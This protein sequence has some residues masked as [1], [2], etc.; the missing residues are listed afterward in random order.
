M[1]QTSAQWV[2][3]ARRDTPVEP[4]E[5]PWSRYLSLSQLD[6][7]IDLSIAPPAIVK[8]FK[9]FDRR[10]LYAYYHRHPYGDMYDR[11]DP[12]VW[13]SLRSQVDSDPRFTVIGPFWIN[14]SRLLGCERLSPDQ[15]LNLTFIDGVILRVHK[16]CQTKFLE[17]LGIPSG[18]KEDRD[19]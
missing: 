9:L 15:Q 4:Y 8:Q 6:Y 10:G 1:T 11:V 12:S 14:T 3:I 18:A 13:Q 7:F 19:T 17:V 16:T 5:S 2:P